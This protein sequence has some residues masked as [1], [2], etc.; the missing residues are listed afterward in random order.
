M[1]QFF[2]FVLFTTFISGCLTID[3][4]ENYQVP[5]QTNGGQ[6]STFVIGG[7]P[8]SDVPDSY[9]IDIIG[10][11]PKSTLK[12]WFSTGKRPTQ[13]QFHTWMDSYIHKL[14]DELT[15]VDIVGL[16]DTLQ[17][18]NLDFSQIRPLLPP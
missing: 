5:P 6:D 4:P 3:L 18:I 7:N 15:E 14:D 8:Q 12:G 11:V 16:T 17:A 13:Q 2:L 10:S 1:K 9:E